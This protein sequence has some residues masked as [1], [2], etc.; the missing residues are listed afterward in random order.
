MGLNYGMNQ[1]A[2]QHAAARSYVVASCCNG[3]NRL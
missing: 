3:P 1:K 2:L